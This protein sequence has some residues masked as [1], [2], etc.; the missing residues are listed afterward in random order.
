MGLGL[1][2]FGARVGRGEACSSACAPACLPAG[3][4]VCG[5]GALGR[6]R[7]LW[8]VGLCHFVTELAG[9]LSLRMALGEG[10]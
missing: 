10:I 4:S 1:G 8:Y 5:S 3:M 9:L 7:E 2:V 6:S